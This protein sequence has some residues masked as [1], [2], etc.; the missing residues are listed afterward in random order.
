MSAPNPPDDDFEAQVRLALGEHAGAAHHVDLADGALTK[1]RRIRRRRVALSTAAALVTLA[2]A[3]PVGAQLIDS[4]ATDQTAS[5]TTTDVGPTAE[6]TPA[7]ISLAKLPQGDAPRVAYLAGG[8]FFDT[9][10]GTHSA[11]VAAD[12]IVTDAAAL[13]DGGA[14]LWQ[15]PVD[16][17]AAKT[18]T[19]SGGSAS[20][21]P[22]ADSVSAP[23]IDQGTEA[24]V[25]ALHNTDASGHPAKTDTIVSVSALNGPVDSADTGMQVR[26]VMGAKDGQV[27]F[28]AKQVGSGDVVGV[29]D[30]QGDGTVTTPWPDLKTVTAVSPDESLLAGLPS[31]GNYDPGQRNCSWLVDAASGEMQ[32]TNCDWNPVEFSPDAVRV[33]AIPSHRDGLGPTSLGVLDTADGSVVQEFRV[34]NGTF[35]RATFDGSSEAIVAV[36]T[37]K[38]QSSIVRCAIDGSTCDLATPSAA[39]PDSFSP[40]ALLQPYQLT[41]N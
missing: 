1:A 6:E 20:D 11:A 29:V 21:L 33:L 39:V 38:N 36:V 32:W 2:V 9:D 15:E 37:Q 10:G 14:L 31:R 40:E 34:R 22:S 12:H 8:T 16:N 19:V 18:V 27:V 41:A 24:A 30:L 35:G 3:V 23:A 28:N 7:R 4:G 13:P 25:F 26:Q 17:A 5:E